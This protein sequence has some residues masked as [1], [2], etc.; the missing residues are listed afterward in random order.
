MAS[1]KASVN[2]GLILII[3]LAFAVIIGLAIVSYT[4]NITDRAISGL[5]FELNNISFN[6]TYQD[7][8][9]LG[10]DNIST[11]LPRIIS[12]GLVLGMVVCIFL[13][14]TKVP[15]KPNI[16]ILLDI[17]V[18]I[19]CE[20]IAVLISQT[21]QNNILN[22]S[23]ELLNIFSTTLS[24]GSRFILNLPT[25]IPTIGVITIIIMYIFRKESAEQIQEENITNISEGGFY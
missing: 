22:I 11:A 3:L 18:L 7:T 1:K 24:T 25:I 2:I 15:V 14:S 13:I 16:W 10:M 23:P 12:I 9:H 5:N 20:F 6:Q 19:L 17:V 21:F 4:A 8:V